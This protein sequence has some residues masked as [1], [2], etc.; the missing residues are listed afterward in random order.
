MSF[1]SEPGLSECSQQTDQNLIEVTSLIR[2]Q[3]E[4]QKVNTIFSIVIQELGK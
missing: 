1:H 2:F 4:I 3:F